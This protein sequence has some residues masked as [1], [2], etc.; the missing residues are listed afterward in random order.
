MK[1]IMRRIVSNRE[2]KKE[3]GKTSKKVFR[4]WMS[5]RPCAYVFLFLGLT[6]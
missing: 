1:S 5:R 4:A 6:T 2:E 3:D